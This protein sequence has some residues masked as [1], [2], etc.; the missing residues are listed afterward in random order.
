MLCE[1]GVVKF[2]GVHVGVG[3]GVILAAMLVLFIP[4]K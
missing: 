3:D 2:D 1:E 4:G